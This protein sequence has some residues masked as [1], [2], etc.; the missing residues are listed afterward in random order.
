VI[1]TAYLDESGTHGESPH[2]VMG[3]ML[4]NTRQW[5]RFEFNF[6]RVKKRHGFRI[7][8]TKKFKRRT[9]D[10]KGWTDNQCL[11]LMND[12]A[13]LTASAF[14][15]GV[16]VLLENAAYEAEYKASETPRKLRLD[17]K[18]GLCFRNCLYFFALEALKR[19]HR[20]RLPVLNFVLESG[21][22][23]LGDALRIFNE[24]KAELKATDSEMLG[25]IT[26]ADK[27]E[28]DP[29]MMADFLAHTAFMRGTVRPTRPY[30]TISRPIAM[31]RTMGRKET[32][33]TH[34]EFE[35]GGLTKLKSTLVERLSAKR[36]VSGK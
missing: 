26:P 13:P 24:I 10:F 6:R 19:V 4:A 7:F 30:G 12:L 9:G 22:K 1:L 11:A 16:T 25:T 28:C 18:Y 36:S 34:L 32:G 20:G 31:S 35:L 21:H 33:V 8:H 29:L 15:E 5:E 27:D 14:T 23:N 2:T 17:S 3:G